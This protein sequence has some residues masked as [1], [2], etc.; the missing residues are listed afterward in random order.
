MADLFFL[1]KPE[2]CDALLGDGVGGAK[3]PVTSGVIVALIL[4]WRGEVAQEGCN[5]LARAM[6]RIYH[7]PWTVRLA[8]AL[9]VDAERAGL[10]TVVRINDQRASAPD[11]AR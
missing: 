4:I 10:G 1:P 2:H 5:R 6:E 8:E 9:T 11:A 3:M 7:T